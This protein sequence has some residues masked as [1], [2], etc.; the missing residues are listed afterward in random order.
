MAALSMR[1]RED[2]S[3]FIRAFTGS[4]RFVLDYLVE[5]VLDRQSPGIQEFLLQTSIL[6]RMTA[7]LCDAV[8]DRNDSQAILTQLEQANLFLVPLDDER[9]WY[10]YHHLFADLLR[11]RL[12]QT[13]P[14]Q[15]SALHR[16][17]SKWYEQNEL[18]ADAVS[19]ALA[20]GDIERV[21]RLVEGNAIAI[22]QHGELRSLIR[23]LDALPDEIICSHPWLCIAYAWVLSYTSHVDGI[24]P[25]LQETEKRLDEIDDRAKGRRSAGR[26]IGTAV[27]SS[28]RDLISHPP[29][30]WRGM[31]C[32]HTGIVYPQS[33]TPITYFGDDRSP[34]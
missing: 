30:I 20:A 33:P 2:V 19:H 24:G 7:S 14:D 8:T 12:E 15:V 34:S 13:W 5:E 18:L 17:A 31:F 25:L 6:E 11:G 22:V 4:H 1:G 32:F 16:W 29:P 9:R 27:V 3:G 28:L 23:W 21:A 10:R 26:R